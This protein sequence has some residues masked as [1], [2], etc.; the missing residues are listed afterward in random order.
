MHKYVEFI[1]PSIAFIP[2]GDR[3]TID[4]NP[5]GKK[6]VELT[7]PQN[8]FAEYIDLYY[9]D[10]SY[11]FI[12]AE[13]T[14][15]VDK[16]DIDDIIDSF[17][18]TF[19]QEYFKMNSDT[20]GERWSLVRCSKY[21]DEYLIKLL[22]PIHEHHDDRTA[23]TVRN[24]DYINPYKKVIDFGLCHSTYDKKMEKENLLLEDNLFHSF[25]RIGNI[26][27]DAANIRNKDEEIRKKAREKYSRK[28]HIDF[29]VNCRI[30]EIINTKLEIE[31]LLH[32]KQAENGFYNQ[33]DRG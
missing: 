11:E 6:A 13:I 7:F 22:P 9:E 30:S 18:T 27:R 21:S 16:L 33:G 31:S 12:L 32:I 15:K 2:D 8:K 28:D 20:E 26:F 1:S 23:C 4:Y 29:L 3:V 5:Q 17:E 25:S 19:S 24:S 10:I 14:R